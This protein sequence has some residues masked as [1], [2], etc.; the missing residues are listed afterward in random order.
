VRVAGSK[1][2]GAAQGAVTIGGG[3]MFCRQAEA[4]WEIW[5]AKDEF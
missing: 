1:Y 4:S 3:E 5:D 2:H